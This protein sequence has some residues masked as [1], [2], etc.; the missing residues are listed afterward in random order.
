MDAAGTLF[1]DGAELPQHVQVVVDR[2]VADFAAAQ[3]RD[4][5][6]TDRVD[7][8]TAQ[9]DRDAGIPC[10]RVDGRV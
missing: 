5:G 2:A 4:E 9:Q 7:Q 3:V 8:G 10:M 1:H 6:L